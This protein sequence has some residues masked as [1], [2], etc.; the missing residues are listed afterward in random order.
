VALTGGARFALRME[1][2]FPDSARLVTDSIAEAM[3][4]DE[5]TR[6]RTSSKDKVM[7]NGCGSAGSWTWTP[8]WRAGRVRWR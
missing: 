1:D 3:D 7:V 6:A 4:F 8:R 2:L 5:K